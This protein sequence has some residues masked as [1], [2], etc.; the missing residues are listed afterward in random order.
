MKHI[1]GAAQIEL[2][3]TSPIQ[4]RSSSKKALVYANNVKI[5]R[6]LRIIPSSV[7]VKGRSLSLPI[8]TLVRREWLAL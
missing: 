2:I 6:T 3:I 4:C 5:N 8:D 1:Q 7:L